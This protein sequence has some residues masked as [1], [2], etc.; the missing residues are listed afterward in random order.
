MMEMIKVS[1]SMSFVHQEGKSCA[2]ILWSGGT[3]IRR[4]ATALCHFFLRLNTARNTCSCCAQTQVSRPR[5]TINQVGP[6]FY[7][8]EPQ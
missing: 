8:L 2:S 1:D 6:Q 7:P 4:I 5:A 3:R